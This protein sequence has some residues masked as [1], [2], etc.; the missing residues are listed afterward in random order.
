M[1]LSLLPLVCVAGSLLIAVGCSG[2]AYQS[3]IRATGDGGVGA[4]DS[5]LGAADAGTDED[6]AE[7]DAAPG[8]DAG[9][10]DA[11]NEEDASR[12]D[13]SPD[14]GSDASDAGSDAGSLCPNPPS[15]GD[16]VIDELMIASKR[17]AGDD[18][19]WVEI[20]NT[21]SCTLDVSGIVVSSP[22][23][24]V[25]DSV[26]LPA[27]TLLPAGARLIV[28]NATGLAVQGISGRVFPWPASVTDVL[29]NGGDSVRITRGA[30]LI[31]M[32]SYDSLSDQGYGATLALPSDCAPIRRTDPAAWVHSAKVFSGTFKGTP[33][34]TNN[35]VI[36]P[37]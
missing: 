8:A 33:L 16:L 5:S 10:A 22:R 4:S 7:S 27:G 26:T 13:A 28:G 14:A 17:G 6:D 37:R 2:S 24:A 3:V 12:A 19:E 36:C 34:A 23:G 29:S 9:Q 11:R 32:F 1:K 31:D 18:G 21:K 35:D 25:A 15:A 30:A 20:A